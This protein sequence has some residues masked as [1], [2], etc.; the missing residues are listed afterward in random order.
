[1]VLDLQ[2]EVAP[3]EVVHP[4]LMAALPEDHRHVIQALARHMAL[5]LATPVTLDIVATQDIPQAALDM[6]VIPDTLRVGILVIPTHLD[7]IRAGILVIRIHL[8]TSR[9]DIP[10][11][12]HPH[13]KRALGHNARASKS[14]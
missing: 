10:T 9:V 13:P 7:T 3:I 11:R 4:D 5:P 12:I 6:A 14:V 1:M 2:A 8:D